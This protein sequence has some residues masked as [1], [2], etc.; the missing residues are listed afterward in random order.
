MMK[1]VKSDIWCTLFNSESEESAALVFNCIFK[2]PMTVGQF[3]DSTED[4]FRRMIHRSYVLH[5]LLK[6]YIH[7]KNGLNLVGMPEKNECVLYVCLTDVQR[8]LYAVN[9]PCFILFLN[10]SRYVL[11]LFHRNSL[12]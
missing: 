6:P 11:Y 5:D 9:H 8:G 2:K 1:F 10:I 7:R 3:I 12:S 4:Q